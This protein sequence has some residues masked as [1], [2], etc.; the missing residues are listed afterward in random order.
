MYF[1][2]VDGTLYVT[3]GNFARV[4]AYP[5]FSRTGYIIRS[6]GLQ[7]PIGA[8]VD[9]SNTI[10]IADRVANN[11]LVYIQRAG[12][13]IGTIPPKGTSS[14]SCVPTELYNPVSVAID[15]FN[16]AYI[17]VSGCCAVIKW[18]L[19][20]TNGTFIAG[21]PGS[22]GTASNQLSFAGPIY[23]DEDRNALYVSDR[24]S[25]RI[26]KF[27]IGGNGTGI[28][29][30]GNGTAGIGLNELNS[31][32]GI[33]VSRDGQTLYIADIL[34]N[35]IMKWTIGATQGSAVAGD[36]N[37]IGGSASQLLNR[38]IGV[39]LDSHETY[40]YVADYLNHRV[41]RVRIR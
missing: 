6:S 14:T 23:L 12:I 10:Y 2:S 17:S 8:F 31:P 34:N 29:V 27:I 28:V 26:K 11:G 3:D 4:Q 25:H 41:Q 30:A 36:V 38:P 5:L 37:G 21:Q 18:P 32:R 15:R 24:D 1:S 7:N 39:T 40:L 20:S 19:N 33:W 9:S 35:R 22:C 13:D 16:N